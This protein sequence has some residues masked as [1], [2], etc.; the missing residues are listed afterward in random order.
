MNWKP[1]ADVFFGTAAKHE[2]LR[3]AC[4]YRSPSVKWLFEAEE[5]RDALLCI[6]RRTG[7]RGSSAEVHIDRPLPQ[8]LF[9]LVP[10]AQ[11]FLLV[12]LAALAVCQILLHTLL[13]ALF[14]RPAML[15]VF[16]SLAATPP[17]DYL[18]GQALLAFAGPACTIAPMIATILV[19]QARLPAC[20]RALA[21]EGPVAAADYRHQQ[22]WPLDRNWSSQLGIVFA[23]ALA[24][25]SIGFEV[26]QSMRV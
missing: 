11:Q 24:A 10:M 8:L 20:W 7:S 12:F 16:L 26:H 15:A 13:F 9:N 1:N 17:E 22:L 5:S 21:G 23:F 18:P 14:E 4:D 6:E 19:R 25:L 2:Q 3:Q